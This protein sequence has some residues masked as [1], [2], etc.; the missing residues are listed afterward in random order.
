MTDTTS[1]GAPARLYSQ[2]PY[3]D[4]RVGTARCRAAPPSEPDLIV[5]HHPAQAFQK[6]G[7]TRASST[8][9]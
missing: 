7:I 6:P 4:R 3:D 8:R 1:S 5:S 2:T 9:N